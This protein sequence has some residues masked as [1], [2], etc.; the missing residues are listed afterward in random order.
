MNWFLKMWILNICMIKKKDSFNLV[1]LNFSIKKN[2]TIGIVGRSGSGKSTIIDL[3]AGLI[4]PD[5][6]EILIDEKKV[7]EDNKFFWQKILV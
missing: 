5:K 3:I 4:L 7:T 6:G 2:E 1:N